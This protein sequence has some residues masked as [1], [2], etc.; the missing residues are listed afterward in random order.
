VGLAFLAAPAVLGD[1][2]LNLLAKY[3]C[4][5]IVAVGIGLAWGQGGMLT[6]GQGVFF[7]LGGYAMAMHLKLQEAGP[8][9]MPDF[10]SWS[11]VGR[12]PAL[13]RPFRSAWVALP[14]VVIAPTAV[15]VVL[16]ML[17]FRRRVR[18]AYFAIL[19]Q[20]LAGAFVILLVG[21]QGYTG[22]TNGL[23][24]IHQLFGYDLSD[25]AN[26]RLLYFAAAVTL[27]L[28]YLAARQLVASRY[29]RLLIA[30]RDGEDRVRFLGY[31]PALVKVVA[32][33]VSAAMA[34][35]AGALFVPIVGII[36]PALLGIAP[37]IEM[38]IWVAL[39][40]RMTLVGPVLGA[41]LANYARTSLSEQ[42]PSGWL[43]LQGAMFVVLIAFAPKGI[44]G[45]GEVLRGRFRKGVRSA[46]G[47]AGGAG[48][49]SERGEGAVGADVEPEPDAVTL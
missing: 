10:M 45:I 18:G 5:A 35:I 44:A 13:W 19:T 9:N 15:A 6:L 47:T 20:A 14:A 37:S 1:F 23:T 49:P 22:G 16:G 34:G 46:A 21:Q 29:G 2:R 12:L 41:L 26:Q 43:Y 48:G 31:N 27:G 28:A 39:G 25:P 30:I 3:L 42:F 38:V 33:G 32:F 11:G 40:G 8:G 36:S 7:G 4:F 17:V 24:N